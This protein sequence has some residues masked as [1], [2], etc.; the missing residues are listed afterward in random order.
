MNIR[1]PYSEKNAVISTN[2]QTIPSPI[3]EVK[4]KHTID[5]TITS[6]QPNT[7]EPQPSFLSSSSSTNYN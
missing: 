6:E 1:S 7:N 3:N 4:P 5:T 2:D